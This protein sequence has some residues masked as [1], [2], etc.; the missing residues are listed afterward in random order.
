MTSLRLVGVARS[1]G[2]HP[3]LRGIDLDVA[4]GERVA[5]VGPSGAGKTTLLRVLNLGL[6]PDGGRYD[7]AGRDAAELR[8]QALRLAR[9]GI[10]TIHQQHDVVGR[11]SVLQNILA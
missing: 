6:R 3:V 9:T 4:H 7:L 1:L 2:G 11:L 8:G 5:V 10:A